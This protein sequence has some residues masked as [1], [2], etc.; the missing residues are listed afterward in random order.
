MVARS[1]LEVGA[2]AVTIFA[3][4]AK[5]AVAFRAAHLLA[6]SGQRFL[7]GNE[8]PTAFLVTHL[9]IVVVTAHSSDP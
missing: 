2:G 6:P 4:R 8:H 7:N 9:A 5:R 1:M 3:M